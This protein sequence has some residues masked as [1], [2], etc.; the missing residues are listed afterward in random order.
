MTGQATYDTHDLLEE[1][2]Y[3][4]TDDVDSITHSDFTTFVCKVCGHRHIS[5]FGYKIYK[6]RTN[7]YRGCDGCDAIE[8]QKQKQS[9]LDK[10]FQPGDLFDTYGQLIVVNNV[11]HSL[12]DSVIEVDVTCKTC[13]H[14]YHTDLDKMATYYKLSG[15]KHLGCHKC[16]DQVKKNTSTVDT[17]HQ[18][19]ADREFA[20][21]SPVSAWSFPIELQCNICG[22]SVIASP[23]R[24]FAGDK[25]RSCSGCNNKR[26]NAESREK[27]EQRIAGCN[28]EII[29]YNGYAKNGLF[30][31]TI[32]NHIW[33]TT[34]KKIV[35]TL[36]SSDNTISGCA[37]CYDKRY[38]ERHDDIR[39]ARRELLEERFIIHSFKDF[40]VVDEITVTNKRCGHTFTRPVAQF[41]DQ[42]LECPI[43]RG[44]R[45]HQNSVSKNR[46]DSEEYFDRGVDLEKYSKTVRRM[47]RT[48]AKYGG[49]V[50]YDS[51]QFDLDHIVS[52]KLCYYRNVPPAICAHPD[53]LEPL[54]KRDNSL[55]RQAI[56]A[57]PDLLTPYFKREMEFEADIKRALTPYGFGNESENPIFPFHAVC[58]KDDVVVIFANTKEMSYHGESVR[59]T[60]S[61][62]RTFPNKKIVQIDDVD[63]V[64]DRDMVITHA[65]DRQ[66]VVDLD[67]IVVDTDAN[68]DLIGITDGDI[69]ITLNM[70][71]RR[72][73]YYASVNKPALGVVDV[74]R[75][76][77]SERRIK[78]YMDPSYEC[79]D[80]SD[81]AKNDP[82]YMHHF[83]CIKDDTM[84]KKMQTKTVDFIT[85]SQDNWSDVRATYRPAIL[86]A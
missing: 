75:S 54:H 62:Q 17:I 38:G 79:G 29:E 85:L 25:P 18:R 67:K 1:M 70:T 47:T 36:T 42:D 73:V 39:Q 48:T 81:T 30:R 60:M 65:V 26:L 61:I 20:V 13:G 77:C 7:Q 3:S 43:C 83:T 80:V 8:H 14:E 55:K 12:D 86:I 76:I 71:N 24:M 45:N 5:K 59:I 66:S 22:T 41:I 68:D 33:K 31:C 69:E 49:H 51:D 72:S 82:Q 35:E 84:I 57:I 74:I 56:S 2:Q 4:I 34:P 27:F 53:N 58:W 78:V 44:E 32:D 6:Y 23:K 37:K 9:E 19:A 11:E 28:V 15:S 63:W 46:Y 40:S 21:N 16:A 10:L 64:N 50:E 52:V